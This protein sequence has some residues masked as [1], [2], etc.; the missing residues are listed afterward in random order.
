MRS[1]GSKG[2]KAN[3][4]KAAGSTWHV[5]PRELAGIPQRVQFRTIG[6][7]ASRVAA[8]DTVVVHGG[9]YREHVERDAP[10]TDQVRGRARRARCRDGRG[11][12]H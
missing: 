11:R 3:S 1:S 10:Q 12:G 6:E 9:T 2:A 8:G 4:R 7:A 5:S